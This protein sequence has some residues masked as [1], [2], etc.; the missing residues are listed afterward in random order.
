MDGGKD[1]IAMKFVILM[2]IYF[3]LFKIGDVWGHY[4]EIT[5]FLQYYI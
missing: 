3:Y 1:A 4:F 2:Y 5:Y